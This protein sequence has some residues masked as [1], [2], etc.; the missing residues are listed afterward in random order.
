MSDPEVLQF[1]GEDY[2]L[3]EGRRIGPIING[4]VFEHVDPS[5]RCEW[6]DLTAWDHLPRFVRLLNEREIVPEAVEG[7]LGRGFW[8]DTPPSGWERP[9]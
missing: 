8:M 7:N 4:H 6:C 3:V 1:D 9:R 2:W 5:T